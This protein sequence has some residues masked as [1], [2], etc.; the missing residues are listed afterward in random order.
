MMQEIRRSNQNTYQQECTSTIVGSI[1]LTTYNRKTYRVDDIDWNTKPKSTFEVRRKGETKMVSFVEYYQTKY[2][3]LV[4]A[5]SKPM[6][7]SRQSERDIRKGDKGT[8]SSSR[9]SA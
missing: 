6:L 3:Q 5:Q 8:N 7:V 1:V 2:R 9:N 4:T